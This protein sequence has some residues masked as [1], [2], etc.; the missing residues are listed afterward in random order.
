MQAVTVRE[1]VE[2][3]VTTKLYSIDENTSIFIVQGWRRLPLTV[4]VKGI[5]YLLGRDRPN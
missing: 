5:L 2:E 1:G 4:T 3:Y